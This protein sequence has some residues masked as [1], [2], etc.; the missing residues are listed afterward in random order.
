MVLL[1]CQQ[2]Y[3]WHK[4]FPLWQIMRLIVLLIST[5]LNLHSPLVTLPAWISLWAIRLLPVEPQNTAIC[6]HAQAES[7]CTSAMTTSGSD[8]P[9]TNLL[10][11]PPSQEAAAVVTKKPCLSDTGVKQ[12]RDCCSWLWEV[13]PDLDAHAT[14]LSVWLYLTTKASGPRPP[15]LSQSFFPLFNIK[16]PAAVDVAKWDHKWF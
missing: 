7:P 12:L 6:N 3:D 15:M 5:S 4:L 8:Q 2:I 13:S 11:C 10:L 14:C 16:I 1:Y 9:L